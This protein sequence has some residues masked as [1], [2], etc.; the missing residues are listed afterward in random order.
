MRILHTVGEMVEACRSIQRPLGLVPT[1]GYL[2]QGH[3]ALV[4]RAREE[5]ATLAVSIFVNSSQ[6]GP[7]ED[8]DAYPRDLPRDLLILEGER[9]DL[10]F[11]P[12]VEEMYPASADTWVGVERLGSRLEGQHRSGHF[13][14]VATVVTKLFNIVRPD[15]AYFGQKDGQQ[16]VVIRRMVADLNMGVTIVVVP[17]VRKAD[18]LALS[19]RNVYL[20]PEQRRAAPT[21]YRALAHA[22]GMWEEGERDGEVLRQ[23]VRYVLQG[24]PLIDQIDYI[25]VA[26]AATL[27]EFDTITGPALVSAAVRIGKARLIDNMVLGGGI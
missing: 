13:R 5:N 6:F 20:T 18:G 9:A 2:H 3:L 24:E 7:H 22:Q 19:S 14:G 25:S 17:T 11:A 8:F 16:A 15:R 12:S 23:E 4:G 26:D 10:V 27:E 21:I 1:M